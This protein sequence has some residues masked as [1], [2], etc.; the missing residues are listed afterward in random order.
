MCRGRSLAKM[1]SQNDRWG[2]A[3]TIR[4][5]NPYRECFV[6]SEQKCNLKKKKLGSASETEKTQIFTTTTNRNILQIC[7]LNY[8]Q[9]QNWSRN[10]LLS[11][12]FSNSV[13]YC[14][15][16]LISA[17]DPVIQKKN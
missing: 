7:L 12:Y 1:I 6:N 9:H 8:G 11:P 5:H 17:A 15:Y 16:V 14:N 13:Y 4:R 2:P 3:C 10:L